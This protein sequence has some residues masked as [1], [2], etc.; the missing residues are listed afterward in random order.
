MVLE[1]RVEER[2][3]KSVED[4]GGKCI[5]LPAHWYRGIPDR[6]VLLPGGR[7]FFIEL[8]RKPKARTQTRTHVHQAAWAKLLKE[9]G[10]NHLYIS[11][12]S[13]L[14]TF[15]KEHIQCNP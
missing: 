5:K 9:L 2:L 15:E 4:V 14:E 13:Q 8:K 7:I 12:I 6:L 11:G 3:R 10:F 1:A